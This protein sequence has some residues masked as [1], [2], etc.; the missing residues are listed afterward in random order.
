MRNRAGLLGLAL[1]VAVVVVAASGLAFADPPAWSHAHHGRGHAYGRSKEHAHG[2]GSHGRGSHGHG[3]GSTGSAHGSKKS[4]KKHAGETHPPG[5]NGTIKIEGPPWDRGSNNEPHPGCTFAINFFGFDQGNL[6]ATYTL[7][8]HPPSGRGTLASGRV[9]IGGDPAGGGRDFDGTTGPID[10]SQ[11]LASSGAA[12]KKQGYHVAV[13]VHA[14]GSIGSD[15]KHKVFW[16]QDCS[17]TSAPAAA[18]A[19]RSSSR[20]NAKAPRADTVSSRRGSARTAAAARPVRGTPAFT[21]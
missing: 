20:P 5:N 3:N 10:L 15:V 4:S 16:V 19:G 8:L 9:F 2:H 13:T 12:A 7:D 1:S 6:Y 14:D 21:G 18:H 11:A 17:A